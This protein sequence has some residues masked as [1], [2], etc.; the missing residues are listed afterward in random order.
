MKKAGKDKITDALNQLEKELALEPGKASNEILE[1]YN[2]S[3]LEIIVNL[4]WHRKL[5][6]D[7]IKD[8]AFV[9]EM[10]SWAQQDEN[11]TM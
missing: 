3:A 9:P 6:D 11:E 8:K 4:A 2:F 10:I 7:T 5:I 1:E